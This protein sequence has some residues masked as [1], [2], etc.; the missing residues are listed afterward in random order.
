M[1]TDQDL[2][3]MMAN[4]LRSQ[5]ETDQLLKAT[6]QLLKESIKEADRRKRESDQRMQE[7]DRLFKEVGQRLDRVGKQL[8]ELGNKFGSFTEGLAWPSMQKILDERF[9]MNDISPRRR[10][11]LNGRS[12]EIDVLARDSTGARDEVYIVEIK[13]HLTP[14]GIDQILKTISDFPYFFPDLND[15][16]IYGLIAAV[17]IPDNVRAAV[18]DQGLYLAQLNDETFRLIVPDDFK[19]KAFG[20]AARPN[21]QPNGRAKKKRPRAK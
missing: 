5:A 18:I 11:R 6:D 3:E 10:L 21:G 1:T 14:E 15:R 13:S 4:L 12:L 16:K 8:G 2:R 7:T 17:D 9:G 20:P 19:P